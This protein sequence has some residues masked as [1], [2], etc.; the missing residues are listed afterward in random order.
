MKRFS[1]FCMIFL[2][3]MALVVTAYAPAASGK[4]PELPY[5]KAAIIDAFNDTIERLV[6][7]R[8]LDPTKERQEIQDGMERRRYVFT[9]G[10]G[11]AFALNPGSEFPAGVFSFV[12]LDGTPE[13]RAAFVLN[14][15]AVMTALTPEWSGQQRGEIGK[16]IGLTGTFP[17][18]GSQMSVSQGGLSFVL[19]NYGK[20]TVVFAITPATSAQ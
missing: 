12:K 20:D 4:E 1:I 6:Q 13:N 9:N 8:P 16:A 17:A 7:I 10:C 19:A 3:V 5:T 11:I 15:M 2:T 18:D 14:S